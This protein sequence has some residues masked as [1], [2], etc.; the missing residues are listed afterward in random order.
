VFHLR[1]V[2][3]NCNPSWSVGVSPEVI[4]TLDGVWVF[5]LRCVAGEDSSGP[6]L[7]IFLSSLVLLSAWFTG[8]SPLH[9]TGRW[10]EYLPTFTLRNFHPFLF[11]TC[12]NFSYEN[13]I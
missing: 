13:E 6:A 10:R 7:V 4:V 1:C 9:S 5:D 2:A 11:C 3:G 8:S 12:R